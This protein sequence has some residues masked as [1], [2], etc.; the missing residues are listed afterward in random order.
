MAT[1]ERLNIRGI[2][3]FGIEMGDEQVRIPLDLQ[4]QC[5]MPILQC[6]FCSG[7]AFRLR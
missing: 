1:L 2:R 3:N 5:N 4:Y 6:L 7:S